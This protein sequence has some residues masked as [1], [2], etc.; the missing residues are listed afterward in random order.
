M[1]KSRH[2]EQQAFLDWLLHEI[3][4]QQVDVLLM[5]GDVFDTATPSN[6]AQELYFNFLG[7]LGR[8][9]CRHVVIIAG[10]HDSPS[11]LEAPRQLL[12]HLRIH[13]IGKAADNP[14]DDVIT[15]K[16][17]AGQLELIV[18]A[19]PYLRDRDV[20][21]AEAGENIA[22]KAEKLRQGIS[23]YYQEAISAA[24]AMRAA[25]RLE[26]PVVAMGHLFTDGGKTVEEDGVRDL[27]I[28][29]LLHLTPEIFPA[30]VDYVALGHLHLPQL[31]QDKNHLRYC[32][33]PLP[34]GFNEA[35]Q[36]KIVC[37]VEFNGRQ[38]SVQELAI[39]V[40]QQLR[41]IHGNLRQIKEHLDQLSSLQ[42]SI[43]L[44]VKHVSEEV[45]GNLRQQLEDHLEGTQLEILR[46]LNEQMLQ[47]ALSADD[48][49]EHLQSL[50]PKTV[51]AQCLQDND[52]AELQRE[53]L[54]Q[55]YQEALTAVLEAEP[56]EVKEETP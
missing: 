46:C 1:T 34:M 52:I 5:A 8:T 30:E 4:R 36:Q 14:A 50:D 21:F 29:T 49:L 35:G 7:N 53:E 20:R 33:S 15:L 47:Q 41:S 39:P 32:G 28:G 54:Q 22:D 3:D 31:V 6:A 51:F 23:R 17:A 42:E 24:V 38:A 56:A 45:V 12:K 9:C 37:L 2:A 19:V 44:S 26:I 18:V 10:N 27:Y 11:F 55:T 43:W 16:N 25:A 48:L 40:F 13:V